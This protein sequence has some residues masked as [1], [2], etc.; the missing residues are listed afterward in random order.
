VATGSAYDVG[1]PGIAPPTVLILFVALLVAM[2]LVAF[3]SR[4]LGLPY[5]VALV[6]VGLTVSALSIHESIELS[7]GLVVTVL[8]PGLV[9]E[10]AFRLDGDE[11]RR[12]FGGIAL[13]AVPGV[14]VTAAVVALVLNAGTGLPLNEAFLVGA[15]VSATDPVAVVSTMRRL[16]A[17]RR[18]V[19]LLDAESLFNDGTAALA[20]AVALAAFGFRPPTLAE[21]VIQFSVALLGSVVIGA[22]SGFLISRVIKA[23]S[24]HLIELTLTVLAAYGTYLVADLLHAS[25]I[26]ASVVAGIVLGTYGRRE[27]LSRRA[28]EAIDVVWE[29]LAFILTGAAFLLIGFAIPLDT[30]AAAAV[31]IAWGVV[32]VLTGRAIVVYGLLGGAARLDHRIRHVPPLPLSWLH[33]MNWTGLR[34]AV[35]TA[36]ALSIPEGTPDRELLRGIVFG[37]VLFTLIVQGTTAERVLRRAGVHGD[38]DARAGEVAEDL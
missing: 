29:F 7:P 13:L 1:V 31:S 3:V 30:L 21:D 11:L 14:L 8:V 18:L 9:F 4:R 6:L 17:P 25:G 10:A 32:A 35:A 24:D 16:S 36:L 37:I 12:T 5:T 27:G 26:I 20:F 34:G 19:T 2:P 38:E 33:V 22:L 23:T 28:E 15:I